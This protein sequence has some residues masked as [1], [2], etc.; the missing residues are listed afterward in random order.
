MFVSSLFLLQTL[1]KGGGGC[2]QHSII[3]CHTP[4]LDCLLEAASKI[5]TNMEKTQSAHSWH[6]L[7]PCRAVHNSYA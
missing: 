6:P 4:D 2:S 1:G 5:P 7:P 3:F